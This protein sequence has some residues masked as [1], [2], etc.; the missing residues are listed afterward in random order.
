[1][2]NVLINSFPKALGSFSIYSNDKQSFEEIP[3]GFSGFAFSKME[4]D[5]ALDNSLKQLFLGLLMHDK[6]ILRYDDFVRCIVRIL[7]TLIT[8]SHQL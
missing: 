7:M 8:D 1:M 4:Y 2:S 6:V 5:A 3:K